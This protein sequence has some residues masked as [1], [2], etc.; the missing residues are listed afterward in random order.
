MLDLANLRKRTE[1]AGLKFSHRGEIGK[2]F[3]VCVMN[4]KPG[5]K[6]FMNV[7]DPTVE[8]IEQAIEFVRKA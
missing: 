8:K 2:N 4:T 5:R 1:D 6:R 3:Y 7:T